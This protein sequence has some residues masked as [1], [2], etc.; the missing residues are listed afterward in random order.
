[1][2]EN[3]GKLA[4]RNDKAV[5][6]GDVEPFDS[7]ADLDEIEAGLLAVFMTTL[8]IEISR[9][10]ISAAHF[11]Q[12]PRHYNACPRTPLLTGS[13]WRI[14]TRSLESPKST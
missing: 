5:A 2:Q 6:L 4:V 3:V 13:P 10:R 9:C 11:D 1:V 14:A 7:S 12:P 8:E